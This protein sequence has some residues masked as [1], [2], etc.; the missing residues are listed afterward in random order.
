MIVMNLSQNIYLFV[1]W[2]EQPTFIHQERTFI[3]EVFMTLFGKLSVSQ[4]ERIRLLSDI[5]VG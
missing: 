2:Y 4:K 5:D 3:V 1:I